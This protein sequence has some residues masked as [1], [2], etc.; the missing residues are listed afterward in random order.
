MAI[1][2]YSLHA[3]GRDY[4][5]KHPVREGRGRNLFLFL[6][7][8]CHLP[9]QLLQSTQ[10][11]VTHKHSERRSVVGYLTTASGQLINGHDVVFRAM[12]S[13]SLLY[14]YRR[15]G[16]ILYSLNC[17]QVSESSIHLPV[18]LMSSCHF[19]SG[20]FQEVYQTNSVCTKENTHK[21]VQCKHMKCRHF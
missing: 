13:S 14:G 1:T 7:D 11:S 8:R 15:F 6:N 10:H 20:F 17:T 18:S 21:T 5:I 19:R 12:K 16:E 9:P 2:R 3:R 4:C